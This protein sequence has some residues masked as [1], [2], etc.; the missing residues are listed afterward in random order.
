L[1]EFLKAHPG[2]SVQIEGHTDNTGAA[3]YNKRLSVRRAQAVAIMLISRFGIPAE[4]VSTV[5][6][7][8]ER[9]IESN[10]TAEGRSKNR[11]VVVN[12]E[13]EVEAQR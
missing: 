3:E 9:P 13:V 8:L 1:A 6:Y 12:I 4:R 10:D 11:R 7:G 2:L 5:G